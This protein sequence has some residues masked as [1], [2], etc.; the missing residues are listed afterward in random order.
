[1]KTRT[2]W[3]IVAVAAV[4]LL[5]TGSAG[6]ISARLAPD[7]PVANVINYQGQLT[8]PAGV[9]LDGTFPMRFQLYDDLTG[10]VL[11][12]DTGV[13][14]VEVDHGLFNVAL[15]VDPADF[16]GQGLWLRLYV[17]GEWL[18][19]RQELLAV[20][21]ALSLQPGAVI[22]GSSATN[23]LLKVRNSAVPATGSALWGEA[24]TGMGV[25]G[26]STG[27]NGVTGY[28][29]DAYAVSGYD[30][31]STQAHGYGGYFTSLNGVGVYGYSQASSYYTNMYAPGVYGRSVNGAGVYGKGDGSSWPAYGGVFE[32]RVG[33]SARGT[34][35][36]SVDG[37][38]GTFVS[39]AYRGIYAIGQSGWYDA[40]FAGTGGIFSNGGVFSSSASRTL[41][42]NGG[43]EL[44]QPGDVV[45]IA[46]I[47]ESP[48]GGEP[49]LAVRRADA[50]NGEAVIGVAVQAMQA[51][52]KTPE[53]MADR[54]FLDIEPVE[55]DIPSGGYL[56]IIT[57]GLAPAVKVADDSLSI[58]DMLTVSAKPGAA[59]K[60]AAA[61]ISSAALE[62]S[63]AILGKVAGPVD[64]KSG[65]VPVFVTLR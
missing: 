46:G 45:A 39:E 12:W 15:K 11:L 38:A 32:G 55:G 10:G 47:A 5:I 44:L 62:Y 60:A 29:E 28:S 14:N 30:G 57:H 50:A 31:G 24:A 59:G 51:E 64:I 48:Q 13:F 49:L 42:V 43:D 7:D 65:T 54:E 2:M 16:N 4:L 34:G 36:S 8:S 26:K 56:T 63:G 33:L 37:Y 1:M 3:A 23:W 58:G 9:A 40:Y 21:Y 53:G 18:T 35:S 41:A 27:G 17:D 22:S 20:P 61:G 25:Y 19:P 52:M 6:A